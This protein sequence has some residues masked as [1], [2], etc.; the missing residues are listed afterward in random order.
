MYCGDCNRTVS[1]TTAGTCPLCGWP[2]NSAVV[3]PT[4]YMPLTDEQKRDI[5]LNGILERLER[6]EKVERDLQ[7][8]IREEM[9]DKKIFEIEKW[10]DSDTP[11]E[12]TQ[13]EKSL[14]SY[15]KYLRSRITKFENIIKQHGIAICVGDGTTNSGC[16]YSDGKSGYSCPKCNGMVLSINALREAE[17]TTRYWLQEEEDKK[18]QEVTCSCGKTGKARVDNNLSAGIHCD[19]CWEKLIDD[20]RKRSW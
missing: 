7:I 14:F 18:Q 19:E 1:E 20:A 6:L 5:K 16:D 9:T 10:I 11:G 8:F 17:R 13:M 12:L 4:P 2:N 3:V 15:I